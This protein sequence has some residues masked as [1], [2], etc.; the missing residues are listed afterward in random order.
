M[1]LMKLI[2]VLLVLSLV[3]AGCSMI[4][5][6]EE[7]DRETVIAKVNDQTVLKGDVLDAIENQ[8]QIYIMYG[9]YPEDFATNSA[10]ADYYTDFVTGIIDAMVDNE[11]EKAVAREKGCYEFTAEERS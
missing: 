4:E 2:A 10:Y 11:V 8:L 7:K 5:V 9:Y 6:N 1:R 3:F